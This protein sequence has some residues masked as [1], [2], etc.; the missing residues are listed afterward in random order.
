MPQGCRYFALPGRQDSVCADSS[1]KCCYSVI[2]AGAVSSQTHGAAIFVNECDRKVAWPPPQPGSTS[3]G[4]SPTALRFNSNKPSPTSSAPE[5]ADSPNAEPHLPS[6]DPPPPSAKPSTSRTANW[7]SP[8]STTWSSP[9]AG[10]G[11]RDASGEKG[12]PVV[13]R[14]E[15]AHRSGRRHWACAQRGHRAP[16]KAG[17]V[18]PA[19]VRPRPYAPH[20]GRIEPARCPTRRSRPRTNVLALRCPICSEAF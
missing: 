3:L 15:G 13:L 8:T 20:D 2:A 17:A 4:T 12:Q 10:P 5:P 6:L 18:C 7:A 9:H 19:R 16:A 11:S 1:P 14:D